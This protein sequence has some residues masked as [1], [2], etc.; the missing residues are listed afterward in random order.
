VLYLNLRFYEYDEKTKILKS[1]S[2]LI[3]EFIPDRVKLANYALLNDILD[4]AIFVDGVSMRP[5]TD[6]IKKI[7]I[8]YP[9]KIDKHAK[10]TKWRAYEYNTQMNKS[11]SGLKADIMAAPHIV[12]SIPEY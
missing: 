6:E 1:S 5:G 12:D 7:I 4:V 8:V 10:V 3:D 11:E 9:K 2:S